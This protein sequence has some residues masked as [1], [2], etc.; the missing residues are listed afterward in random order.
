MDFP[1]APGFR[2]ILIFSAAGSAMEC[3]KKKDIVQHMQSSRRNQ[4]CLRQIAITFL[5]L[6]GLCNSSMTALSQEKPLLDI[7]SRSYPKATILLLGTFHFDNPG[8]DVYKQ[9]FSVD[10]LSPTRQHEIEDVVRLLANYQPTKIAVEVMPTGQTEFDSLY[11]A[12][13]DEKKKSD[14][15]EVFQIGFRLAQQ[16]GHERVFCVDAQPNSLLLDYIVKHE[17]EIIT[18]RVDTSWDSCYTNLY[19]YDDSLKT[20]QSL[21]EHLIYLNSPERIQAGHGSYLVGWFKQDGE[22]GYIGTDFRTLWYNRNLRIFRNLQ[23]LTE[24]PDERIL[25]II[26]AGHLPILRHTIQHSPEYR[27]VEL[28]KYLHPKQ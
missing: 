1:S 24:S 18:G 6:A 4:T 27:L 13:C 23:R 22:E 8:F 5:F 26:G 16:L 17:Q 11:T 25:L 21:R 2:H 28:E 9:Q 7:F 12:H 15:N 14:A 10:M 3:N 19:R 20:V